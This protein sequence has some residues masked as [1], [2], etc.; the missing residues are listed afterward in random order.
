MA[1]RFL[2]LCFFVPSFLNAQEKQGKLIG[3]VTDTSAKPVLYATISLFRAGHD[4]EPIKRSFTD[5]RGTFEMTA[6]TGRYLLT[7]T[8]INRASARLI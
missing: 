6:D 7:V 1:Y 5:K 2:L 8:Y 3:T 4:S